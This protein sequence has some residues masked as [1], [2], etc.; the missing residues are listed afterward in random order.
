M[1]LTETKLSLAMIT[2]A[3]VPGRK[4]I[5][6]VTSYG[7]TYK[8]ASAGCWGPQ[9]NYLGDRINS[10]AKKGVCTGT[11]GYIADAEIGEIVGEKKRAGRVV[12]SFVG[13]HCAYWNSTFNH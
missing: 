7:R 6:G 1:N 11:G 8:M 13:V 4:V 9:C 5:V 3:G 2:K 10:P 12:T